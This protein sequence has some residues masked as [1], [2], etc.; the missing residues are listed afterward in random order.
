MIRFSVFAALVA[1]AFVPARAL[2]FCGFYVGSSDGPLVSEATMVVLLRSGTHTVLSMQNDYHGPP[3]DFAMVVPVPEVLSDEDVKVLPQAVFERVERLAAPRLVE[4]WEQDPCQISAGYGSGAGGLGMLGTGRGGGGGLR[5]R[6]A[7][8]TIEAQFEVG[9]YDILI[10]SANDSA[11]LDAWLREREYRIPEGAGEILRP[12]VESGSKFFVAKVNTE[13]VRFEDGRAVLSPLRVHYE[14]ETFALP[15]RL[16]LLSSSGT[17]DLLVHILADNQRYEVANYENVTIPTNLDVEDEVR[18]RFGEVY[19]ALFDATLAAHPGAVV[20]EYAWQAT[21]CDPCP[22]PVL[23]TQDIATLGGDVVTD[24]AIQARSIRRRLGTLGARQGTTTVSRVEVTGDLDEAIVR[25]VLRARVSA[26]DGCYARGLAAN[27]SLAGSVAL[28]WT[29]GS[30]GRVTRVD[31]V[32]GTMTDPG[33]RSCVQAAVRRLRLPSQAA[34][35]VEIAHAYFFQPSTAGA[36]SLTLDTPP[37]SGSLAALIGGMGGGPFGSYVLTRLHYRYD[38]HALG[39]D[40]VFREADPIAGGREHMDATAGIGAVPA[41]SNNFQGRYAIRHEWEGPIECENPVRGRW[42]GPPAGQSNPG[43]AAAMDVATGPRGDGGTLQSLVATELPADL[44]AAAGRVGGGSTT[45]PA[46]GSAT[47]R[48][49]EPGAPEQ[50]EVE[51]AED[52]AAATGGGCGCRTSAPGA[53]PLLPWL[54]ASI[55]FAR[56]RR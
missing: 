8:V 17:Q 16:G 41:R 3:E 14:S 33:V 49:T 1:L 12:Y 2:A 45:G 50:A 42:G 7:M 22:G 26:V 6:G 39:E 37:P 38:S 52:T 10:L 46:T 40:L 24:G 36:P 13:R 44:L 28:K 4:Y 34:G 23:S 5:S 31:V 54:F 43:P 18:D 25:R 32:G 47:E 29:V 19:A 51:H 9:E 56:R 27:P 15:V 30:D 11:G 20:T 35:V 48:A 55:L 21:G 53:A